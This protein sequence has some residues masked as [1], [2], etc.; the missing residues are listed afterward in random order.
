[1]NEEGLRREQRDRVEVLPQTFTNMSYRIR[2][3]SE[4]NAGLKQRGGS[5]TLWIEESVMPRIS[6]NRP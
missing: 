5:L 2:N 4:Y 6:G 3:W 1:M